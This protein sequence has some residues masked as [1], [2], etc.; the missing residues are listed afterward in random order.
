ME[1]TLLALNTGYWRTRDGAVIDRAKGKSSVVHS[2]WREALD[3]IVALIE[4]IR[5]RFHEAVGFNEMLYRVRY[6]SRDLTTHGHEI[7]MMMDGQLRHDR[8]LAAW[9]DEKRNQSIGVLN[10]ILKEIGQHPLA[11]LNEC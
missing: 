8:T 3:R 6:R 2:E 1:D 5:H 9:M 4:E 10:T 11:T 7:E